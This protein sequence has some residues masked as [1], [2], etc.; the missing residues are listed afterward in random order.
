MAPDA[1]S[2]TVSAAN[3]VPDGQ[4]GETA[5]NPNLMP[6]EV[7]GETI[8][9]GAAL[10]S[11]AHPGTSDDPDAVS[12]LDG[13]EPSDES[14]ETAEIE[15]ED[16]E[17]GE[18]VYAPSLSIIE[19]EREGIIVRRTIDPRSGEGIEDAFIELK[20]K[21]KLKRAGKVVPPAD[22]NLAARERA[23][24]AGHDLSGGAHACRKCGFAEW[25]CLEGQPC[26]PREFDAG[27]EVAA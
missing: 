6:G 24:A 8:D 20:D 18:G 14:L 2:A 10:T 22:P 5:G 21:L 11:A 27:G 12:D 13:Q 25:A 4:A 3:T 23:I 9:D 1:D 15:V 7:A 26:N 17:Y 16:D 19:L